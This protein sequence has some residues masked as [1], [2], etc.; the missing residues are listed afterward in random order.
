MWYMEDRGGRECLPLPST[1]LFETG[2]LSEYKA[3]SFDFWRPSVCP[4]QWGCKGTPLAMQL[5][6]LGMHTASFLA[7]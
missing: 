2:L 4:S 3:C 1:L 5:W 7:H 6:V